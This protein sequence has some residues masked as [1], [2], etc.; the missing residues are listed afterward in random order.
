MRNIKFK[1]LTNL[2]MLMIALVIAGCATVKVPEASGGS[3][4]DATVD[5]S[6]EYGAFEKPVVQWE[7]AQNE[8][9]ARCRAWGYKNAAPFGATKTICNEKNNNGVCV[10]NFVTRT[11]QCLDSDK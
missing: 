2:T 10:K 3:R 8:A 9:R 4:A 7:E 1:I 5:L 11:Y 6:Y